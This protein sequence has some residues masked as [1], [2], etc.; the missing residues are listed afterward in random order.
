MD[1]MWP[2]IGISTLL[3]G[4]GFW[5][6]RASN[7]LDATRTAPRKWAPDA[8]ITDADIETHIRAGRTIEAI[9]LYRRR[10]GAG[11]R[12]A[13]HAVD[14]MTQRPGMRR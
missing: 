12:E 7:A 4:V 3:V 10:T 13:K 11:L 5:L 2:G 6:G 8:S 14:A 1:G 9:K